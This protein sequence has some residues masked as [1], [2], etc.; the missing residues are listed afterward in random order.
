MAPQEEVATDRDRAHGGAPR[1]VGPATRGDDGR[2]PDPEKT[3]PWLR[4]GVP[5]VGSPAAGV[6][7]A[8]GDARSCHCRTCPPPWGPGS[9]NCPYRDFPARAVS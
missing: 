5:G 6:C 9:N 8:F 2:G 4:R 3:R 1:G 7:S